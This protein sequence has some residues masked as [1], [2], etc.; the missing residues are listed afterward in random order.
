MLPDWFYA[1]GQVVSWVFMLV[2]AGFL[3]Y[4]VYRVEKER[5]RPRRGDA[6]V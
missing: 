3:V 5:K 2:A 1:V 6:D 4:V